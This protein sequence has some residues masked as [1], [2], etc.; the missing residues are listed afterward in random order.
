MNCDNITPISINEF[1]S[2]N[3][4][5]SVHTFPSHLSINLIHFVIFSPCDICTDNKFFDAVLSE[6]T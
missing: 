1:I 4:I 5:I 6:V 2:K 3:E